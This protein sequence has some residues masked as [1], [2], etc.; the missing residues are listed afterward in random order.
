MIAF[1][2]PVAERIDE[3]APPPPTIWKPD[4]IAGSTA[5][6]AIAATARVRIWPITMIQPVKKPQLTP[7]SRLDHWKIAPD[8]GQR[9]ASSAKHNATHS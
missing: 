9:P 8:T 1:C 2:A 5:C 6:M 7:A 3:S 4:Q